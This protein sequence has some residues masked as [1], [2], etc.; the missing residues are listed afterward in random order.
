MSEPTYKVALSATAGDDEPFAG[1]QP[2]APAARGV[3]VLGPDRVERREPRPVPAV[4]H[5]RSAAAGAAVRVL[6]VIERVGEGHGVIGRAFV[7]FTL[8]LHPPRATSASRAGRRLTGP[9][10]PSDGLSRD[11]HAPPAA[12]RA[13]ARHGARDRA[14]PLAPGAA[15]VRAAR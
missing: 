5:A 9:T 12:D 10:L 1:T 6:C 8:T 11:P 7:P 14:H 13:S 4:V 3:R 15:H 2:L